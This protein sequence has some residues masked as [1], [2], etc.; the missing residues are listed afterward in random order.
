MTDDIIRTDRLFL[1]PLAHSD[2]ARLIALASNEHVAPM[3]SSITL[4]WPHNA[5][6]DWIDRAQWRNGPSGRL[7]V[8]LLDGTLIGSV[9]V[10]PGDAI[11]GYWLGRDYW[12]Q[13]YA[14]E[15]MGAIID[16]LVDQHGLTHFE[17]D[18]FSD[19]PN[20][21]KVLLKLG[22]KPTGNTSLGQSAA[23]TEPSTCVE[24]VLNR[25]PNPQQA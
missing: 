19:N 9:G 5:V 17:A 25:A 14:T 8:C 20:S 1:R 4:P 2:I 13:G 23:R 3:M 24:Y 21:A 11:C 7:G 22:F 18:H 10:S 12:G 16:H 6:K 15:A